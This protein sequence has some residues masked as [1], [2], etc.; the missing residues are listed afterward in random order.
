MIMVAC[1]SK[2]LR[3]REFIL[4]NHGQAAI[5]QTSVPP[6]CRV[7]IYM[8]PARVIIGKKGCGY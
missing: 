3:I 6:L 5:W 1:C 2:I 7:S 8:P 4:K